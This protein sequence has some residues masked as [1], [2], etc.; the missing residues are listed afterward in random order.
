MY[1][2]TTTEETTIPLAAEAE[3]LF[4]MLTYCR[5]AGSKTEKDF[6]KKYI[7]PLGA[8]YDV[9]GNYILAI[10]MAGD[11]PSRVMWSCHTD[12]VHRFG[13]FQQLTYKSGMITLDDLHS[14]CLGADCTTGVWLMRRMILARVPGLYIFHRAE[15]IGGLGSAAI[16]KHRPKTVE[17]IDFAIAF[18]RKGVGSV[19][20]EQFSGVCASQAFVDSIAPMLPGQY[21]ADPTGSF[22]DTDNYTQLISECTNLSVGYY[23][24]HTSKESQ[25]VWHALGLLKALKVFDETKLVAA[26]DPREEYD[27]RKPVPMGWQWDDYADVASRPTLSGGT[28]A[29]PTKVYDYG[30]EP[31]PR[32][33]LEL[34]KDYPDEIADLFEQGGYD[35]ET[36]AHDIGKWR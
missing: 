23:D 5:P 25:D 28:W 18:D 16:A 11:A 7:K 35:V 21:T 17:G 24:Q 12:T 32:S 36:L 27:M 26:R 22:T 14:N 31:M 13:G 15:E 10:P 29:K 2:I 8:Q 20:T 30:Y 3:E 4:D 33:I 6:I 34:V 19:I 9:A 1:A